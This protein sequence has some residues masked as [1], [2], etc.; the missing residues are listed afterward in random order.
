VTDALAPASQEHAPLVKHETDVGAFFFIENEVDEIMNNCQ[1]CGTF[2]ILED[3]MCWWCIADAND[4]DPYVDDSLNEVSM[5]RFDD[6]P[7]EW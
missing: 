2:D 3:G 1:I 4:P 7:P 5:G 6:D